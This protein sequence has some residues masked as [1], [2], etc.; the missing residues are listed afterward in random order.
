MCTRQVEEA[1]KLAVGSHFQR[2]ATEHDDILDL[3]HMVDNILDE[4][5]SER[6]EALR[7]LDGESRGLARSKGWLHYYWN[8]IVNKHTKGAPV[9]NV[10]L[11]LDWSLSEAEL[12]KAFSDLNIT[13]DYFETQRNRVEWELANAFDGL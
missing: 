12:D 9:A 4:F 13:D 10:R 11:L 1:M 8:R 7:W 3:R 6:L 2:Y 5:S